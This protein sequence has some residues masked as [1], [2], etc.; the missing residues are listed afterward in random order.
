MPGALKVPPAVRKRIEHSRVARLATVA[1]D[2]TPHIVPICFVCD[3]PVF[4]TAVDRKPKRVAAEKLMRVRNIEATPR[5][6]L[7][8]DE[9][10]EDWTRLWWVL[11]R[12]RAEMLSPRASRERSRA[13]RLLRAKYPQYAAGM[14]RDDAPIICLTPE[15]VTSWGAL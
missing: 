5:A 2:G 7:L 1:P 10:R 12:G 9:Y 14:L 11:I 13:L 15:R 8:I 3:W 4:Y 6:A